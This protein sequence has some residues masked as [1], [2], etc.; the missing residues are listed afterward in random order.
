MSPKHIIDRHNMTSYQLDREQ[1]QQKAYISIHCSLFIF[2]TM[3]SCKH[4]IA[5]GALSQ[6]AS[7]NAFVVQGDVSSRGSSLSMRKDKEMELSRRAAFTKGISTFGTIVSIA[8]VNPGFANAARSPPTA[9]ELE[10][11][12]VG[13]ERMSYLLDNFD[14]ETTICRVRFQKFWMVN[15]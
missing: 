4:F 10:R 6:L 7:T 13:Y 3:V 11:L 8:T 5:V 15:N 12:K 14:Q 1:K 9:D 2:I